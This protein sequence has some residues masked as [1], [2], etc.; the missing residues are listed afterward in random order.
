MYNKTKILFLGEKDSKDHTK[1]NVIEVSSD[2]DEVKNIFQFYV[3][4]CNV[5]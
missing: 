4:H 5:H 2:D 3:I 1:I